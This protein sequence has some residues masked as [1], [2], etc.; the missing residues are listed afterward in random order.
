MKIT[1]KMLLIT[2]LMAGIAVLFVVQIASAH[3]PVNVGDYTIEVGWLTEPPIA[4]QM[5]AIVVNVS[6]GEEEPV[7]DVSGLV[8]SISYGDQKKTLSLQP[9]GEDTPGQFIAPILP[10]IPGQYTVTLGGK[11]GD[12]DVSADVEP[13]EVDIPD[14]V[15]FPLVESA[16][17]TS[18]LG[19]SGWLAVLGIVL[20]LAGVGLGLNSL[21]KNGQGK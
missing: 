9:L 17:S 7:D 10:T 21:K 12:T 16:S 15:Q 4:G 20:G 1:P 6:N 5:N 14:V 18:G 11:L 2:L 3:T 8:V 19:L 13:E